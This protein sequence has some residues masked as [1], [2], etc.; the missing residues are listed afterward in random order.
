MAALTAA[1]TLTLVNPN[2]SYYWASKLGQW[3]VYGI[4][5]RL[6]KERFQAVMDLL[7]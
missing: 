5:K 6:K 7:A 2:K 1:A 4:E 3:R